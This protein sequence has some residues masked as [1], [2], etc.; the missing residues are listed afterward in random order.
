M[1][2][3]NPAATV[4]APTTGGGAARGA[5]MGEAQLWGTEVEQAIK[6]SVGAAHKAR[7]VAVSNVSVVS[8]LQPGTSL[9]GKTL[10]K[11]DPVLLTGQ[12]APAQNGL[13][14]VPTLGDAPSR[15]W[16]FSYYDSMP[17]T[18]FIVIEGTT[19]GQT[20]WRCTSV[21]GGTLGV[22]ALVFVAELAR[23]NTW[24][25]V[26]TFSAIPSLSGGG[27]KFPATQVPSADANT[28]DDYE[29]VTGNLG[30]TFATP[31]NLSVS[32]AE[33]VYHAI[34][35]GRLVFIRAF[36][37]FTPTFT[38]ASGAFQL[39]GFPWAGETVTG[40]PGL[41]LINQITT[42]FAWPAGTTMVQVNITSGLTVAQVAGR[43]PGVAGAAFGIANLT[44]GAAHTLA[45][46][47]TY[48][49]AA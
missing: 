10:V 38:T 7:L 42:A 2:Y 25:G 11:G 29:E 8:G 22:T 9:D 48:L 37:T 24:S 18:F 36:L 33:Q 28:L 34:K 43:G 49:A 14:I 35:I 13:Y 41:L 32:Y 1:P 45:F 6:Q 46:S 3:T 44:S 39:T 31:G 47:G 23:A 27:I 17:G 21:M 40:N 20:I 19:Y 5:D 26:Q 4:F 30:I 16:A 15:A 12:T